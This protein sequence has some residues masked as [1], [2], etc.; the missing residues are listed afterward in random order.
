MLTRGI[1]SYDILSLNL[2]G[3]L[4]WNIIRKLNRQVDGR[5]FWI[6]TGLSEAGGRGGPKAFLLVPPPTLHSAQGPRPPLRQPQSTVELWQ[7]HHCTVPVVTKISVQPHKQNVSEITLQSNDKWVERSSAT[8]CTRRYMQLHK[9]HAIK[10]IGKMVGGEH[11]WSY[12][13]LSHSV[14]S[15]SLRPHGL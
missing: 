10:T 2:V 1:I 5:Y 13:V 8:W 12:L 11:N 15:Y 4:H 9:M 14:V 6:P 3:Y 7:N